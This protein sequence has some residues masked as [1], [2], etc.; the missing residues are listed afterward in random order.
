MALASRPLS[1]DGAVIMDGDQLSKDD[2]KHNKELY[3]VGQGQD[4]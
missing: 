4:L 1:G 3:L 2:I